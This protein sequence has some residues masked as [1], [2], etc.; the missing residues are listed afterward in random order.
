MWLTDRKWC[1]F[2]SYNPNY[3]ERY[4]LSVNRVVR[5]DETIAELEER[6]VSFWNEIVLP[7]MEK[8]EQL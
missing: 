2:V 8:V 5:D 3:P 6:C 1:D 7:L 4:Q